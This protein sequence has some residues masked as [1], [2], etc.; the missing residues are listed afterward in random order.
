MADTFTY[1]CILCFYIP[2]NK[3]NAEYS[4]PFEEEVQVSLQRLSG[5]E[6]GVKQSDKTQAV[7]ACTHG[8]RKLSWC[9]LI[10]TCAVKRVNT[11]L[12]DSLANTYLLT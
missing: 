8:F 4:K 2:N 12:T 5:D 9:A 3:R 7:C 11:A 1:G 10:G 6:T